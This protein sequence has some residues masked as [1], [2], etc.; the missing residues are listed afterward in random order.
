MLLRL[1]IV[2]LW[3][4]KHIPEFRIMAFALFLAVFTITTLMTLTQAISA[5]FA[6]EAVE[7]LGADLIMESSD[8]LSAQY[9]AFAQKQGIKTASIVEF[10]SMLGANES[11]QLGVVCAIDGSFPLK[12]K[13]SILTTQ[14]TI[15]TYGPPPKGQ[16]WMEPELAQRL[17]IKLND[18][19][20][21]GDMQLVF[22]GILQQ[23]PIAMSSST[24][25][26][27]MVYVNAQDL[28]KMAVIQPGSRVMYRL[29]LEGVEDK[30]QIF[31]AQFKNMSAIT[32]VSVSEGR[33]GI[34]E[35][36]AS[37]KR[38]LAIILLI[39]IFLAGTAIAMCTYQYSLRQQKKVALMRSLGATSSLVISL[40]IISLLIFALL[41][42]IFAI[43]AGLS[44]SKLLLSYSHYLDLPQGK[45]GWQGSAYGSLTG[46]LMLLG[47]ALGPLLA[48]KQASPKN[49]LQ[50]NVKNAPQWQ[51]S[52]I[53]FS[54]AMLCLLFA[55]WVGEG[56]IALRMGAQ[57]VL[58][59]LL[60]FVL[61]YVLWKGFGKLSLIGPLA[62]R[63]GIAYMIRHQWQSM[64][65]W[66][67]FTVVIALLLLIRVIQQDVQQW[68]A[69]LP[70]TTPNYFLLN[71]Q[72]AQVNPLKDWLATKGLKRVYF[73]PVVRG[74]LSHINGVDIEKMN[75]A[76]DP[77]RIRR[78]LN[79][80]WMHQLPENNQVVAG[81]DWHLVKDGQALVS[82]EK[83]F[84]ERQSLKIGDS[85]TFQIG[86]QTISA[87]IIQLRTVH[88]EN[89]TPNFYVIFPP[90]TIENFPH[91][92]MTSFY[93]T[94]SEKSL[95]PAL[96][97]D[98]PE[99][100]VID[101]DIVLQKI[102]NLLNKI[103]LILQ[104]L[105]TIVFVMGILI[106]YTGLLSTLK[107]RWTES[108]MVQI[109]GASKAFVAK[110]LMIEFAVLGF[111]SGLGAS[112]MACAL[113]YSLNEQFFELRFTF[114]VSWFLLGMIGS[115]FT[116]MLF[117]M[118]GARTVF[119][120]SPLWL[121][122][123]NT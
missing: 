89:F 22:T 21:L 69:Q 123:Q 120:T 105:L 118:I 117:G 45:L 17:N 7:L 3:R 12:G 59:I 77:K 65:Q 74:R 75:Q 99:I 62:W 54:I 61:A 116:I 83:K 19:V 94:S 49:I 63:F 121:L 64:I 52:N 57:I 88:W 84:S 115:I 11:Y 91:V 98:H 26:A 29:L 24:S 72:P 95:I 9:Q 71:V 80:T 51:I 82:V 28:E 43:T 107:E 42:L 93:L 8:P 13:L 85:L 97:K 58:I 5:I 18:A 102:R 122:K 81:M 113:A 67:V 109:L 44:V 38:Y 104:I 70:T 46:L 78:A 34:K 15:E 48:L 112:L 1:S 76:D 66:L 40:Q 90:K 100:S 56:E 55:L 103:A 30:L 108:A 79:L 114:D 101:I 14:Q 33:L 119:Q 6:G 53:L 87:K 10:F 27:P 92:Y 41:V 47:F 35:T 39:Q 68:Q 4:E 20:Q 86:E 50:R 96:I 106:M 73:Y 110:V 37:T 25:L 111:L 31:R 60:A 36:L 32:W 2:N 16:V 23:R